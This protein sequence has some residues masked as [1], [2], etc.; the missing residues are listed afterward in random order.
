MDTWYSFTMDPYRNTENESIIIDARLN[1][2]ESQ[3]EKLRAWKLVAG[4]L[5]GCVSLLLVYSGYTSLHKVGEQPCRDEVHIVSIGG[6][7]SKADS[8]CSHT[9]HHSTLTK[10]THYDETTV[11]CVCQ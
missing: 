9:K 4:M 10:D 3:T 11:H 6:F 1:A 2:L 7:S 5:G 8:S